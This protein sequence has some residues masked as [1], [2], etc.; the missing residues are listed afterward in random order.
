MTVGSPTVTM[1]TTTPSDNQRRN[2]NTVSSENLD[3][4][5]NTTPQ[6][7]NMLIAS[8]P[9]SIEMSGGS[10]AVPSSAVSMGEKRIRQK[11]GRNLLGATQ[12]ASPLSPRY[13]QEFHILE[14]HDI[15]FYPS[16]KSYIPLFHTDYNT[17][18]L[19]S[20]EFLKKYGK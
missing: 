3:P 2:I 13:D 11:V 6:N 18:G 1:D 20:L 16:L 9:G 12:S 4:S 14:L 10:F 17:Q 5:Q 8:R 19:H 15:I 7:I